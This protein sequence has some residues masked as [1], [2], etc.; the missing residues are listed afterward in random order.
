MIKRAP[1]SF[2][3]RHLLSRGQDYLWTLLAVATAT[4]VR[5]LLD[6]VLN[7][8]G[9]AISL[10]ALL[11]VC[12]V[13]GLGPGLFAQVLTLVL[14]FYFFPGPP[15][16]PAKPLPEIIAG[17]GAFVGVGLLVALLSDRTRKA[18]RR[19][20]AQAAEAMSQRD[21]LRTTLTCIGDG[22]IVTDVQGR[23]TMMNPAAERITEWSASEAQLR[24][25]DE[26]VRIEDELCVGNVSDL[27][28]N[29]SET[30]AVNHRDRPLVLLSRSGRRL[31]IDYSAAQVRNATGAASGVV[32][33]L[34]DQSARR[35]ADQLLR[36]ADRRKDEFLATLAHEL[37]NPLAPIR[38]GLEVLRASNDSSEMV[39]QVRPLMERQVRQLVRLIDDLLDVSRITQGKLQMRLSEV[40]LCE[41]LRDAVDATR[42]MI[43]EAR[44]E[45]SLDLPA[46]PLWVRAD[47]SR[48]A[49]VFSNLLNNAAKFTPAGGR[50]LVAAT[51]ERDEISVSVTDTGSGIPPDMLDRIF[52]MFAQI[53]NSTEGV[54]S[55]LGIGLTLVKTLV[56][57]H[58]GSIRA[59]S[60]GSGTGST[61]EVRL[62]LLKERPSLDSP[63]DNELSV[64]EVSVSH[65]I[66]VVDDNKDAADALRRLMEILGH[67]VRVA[68]DG[69]TAFDEAAAFRPHVVLMDL[70]MPKIDGFEAARRI[71]AEP[72]GQIMKLVATTGWGHDGVKKQAEAAGFDHHLVKPVELQRLKD[73]LASHGK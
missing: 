22:I 4:A 65:R 29:V 30:S 69:A 7:E 57:L 5:Y 6:P 10:A 55:G 40:P 1:L 36:D 61:F 54:R 49:Q 70:A 26:T 60:D 72:W 14:S 17:L 25:L 41:I 67:E 48:L 71:R 8:A 64:T 62:P 18:Q 19:A 58:G 59:R 45:L 28:D 12:W 11:A 39:A 16:L 63:N 32:L 27:L 13:G 42:P 56:E 21:Q 3:R 38:T 50:I 53:D 2:I 34:R 73:L 37:R 31:P 46:E 35:Q 33:V 47:L 24:P 51:V 44:H 20:E 66:L 15:D 23:I 68:A 43:D 52:E 9:F